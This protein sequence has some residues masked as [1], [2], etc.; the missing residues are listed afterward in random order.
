MKTNSLSK[1]HSL[2]AA[3]LAALAVTGAAQGGELPG[4]RAEGVAPSSWPAPARPAAPSVPAACPAPGTVQLDLL[5]DASITSLNPVTPPLSAIFWSNPADPVLDPVS[6]REV[7]GFISGSA[8]PHQSSDLTA[9][10]LPLIFYQLSSP[11]QILKMQKSSGNIVITY[12]ASSQRA[13]TFPRPG[14]GAMF[15]GARSGLVL[16]ADGTV[17]DWGS[18]GSFKLGQGNAVATDLYAPV[19]VH[20]PGNVGFLTSM[21]AVAAGEPFNVALKSDGTVWTWGDNSLA[22]ELG[23]G[24][25]VPAN[26]SVPV[27]VVDTTGVGSCLSSITAIG[28]RGYNAL[29]LKSDGTVYCWGMNGHGECGNNS[30]VSPQPTPVQVLGLSGSPVIAVESGGVAYS[31]ALKADHT[32]WGWGSNNRGQLADGTF[33]SPRLG[34]QRVGLAIGLADITQISAG[35]GQALALR[36][37]GT[38]WAWGQNDYGQVGDG[39]LT[40]QNTPLQVRGPGGVGVLSNIIMVSGGDC[41]SAAL[42]ADGTVWTWGCNHHNGFNPPPGGSD[43]VGQLGNGDPTYTDQPYPVQVV[44]GEQGGAYLN[45]IV[46]IATRDYHN[47]AL[48]SDGTLYSWGS[49]LNGQLGYGSCC[50]PGLSPVKVIFP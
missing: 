11:T 32:V 8:F 47:Y 22:G 30:T 25:M 42:R 20:G 15:G 4:T 38:V 43:P 21:M 18:D 33:T 12:S 28:A 37:D 3:L 41:S 6:D 24:T 26:S 7:A 2:A 19:Q 36:S 40:N 27:Q 1:P 49:N 50:L 31:L 17:W 48:A 10:T 29:A 44:G 5:R 13:I 16:M 45:A 23:I 35:W 46:L 9:T 34:P 14:G 39:S